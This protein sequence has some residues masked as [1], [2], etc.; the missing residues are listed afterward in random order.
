[1]MLHLLK[2][3]PLLSTVASW[4]PNRPHMGLSGAFK[5]LTIATAFEKKD[6]NRYLS[7]TG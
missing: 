6:V 7:L 1:M 3:Q 5:I 4:R 2:V